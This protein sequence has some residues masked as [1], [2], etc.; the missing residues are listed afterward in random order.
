MPFFFVFLITLLVSIK[1]WFIVRR[2]DAAKKPGRITK[3]AIKFKNRP[4]SMQG[5]G[6]KGAIYLKHD[7]LPICKTI[8]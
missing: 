3:V 2:E 4:D 5:I 8:K 6:F 1:L 7:W